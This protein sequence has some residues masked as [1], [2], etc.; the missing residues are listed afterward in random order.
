MIFAES[1]C[2]HLPFLLPSVPQF[3]K[4]FVVHGRPPAATTAYDNK[5]WTPPPKDSNGH[6]S[7]HTHT[8][9]WIGSYSR[10]PQVT[11]PFTFGP[12]VLIQRQIQAGF[13]QDRLT[14]PCAFVSWNEDSN[15]MPLPGKRSFFTFATHICQCQLTLILYHFSLGAKKPLQETKQQGRFSASR[16]SNHPCCSRLTATKMTAG[17]LTQG[18]LLSAA[19]PEGKGEGQGERERERER[20]REEWKKSSESSHWFWPTPLLVMYCSLSKLVSRNQRQ[21]TNPRTLGENG[22]E[23]KLY[24]SPFAE[25]VEQCRQK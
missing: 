15:F 16:P 3:E 7:S 22:M 13:H 2:N 11:W 1:S 4:N 8:R 18:A 9:P 14:Q 17:W 25:G 19:R 20:E 23:N 6:S 21:C 12:V 24:P 5:C 10:P